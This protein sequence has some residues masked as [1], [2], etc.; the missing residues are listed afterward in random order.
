MSKLVIYVKSF[1]YKLIRKLIQRSCIHTIII[2]FTGID[3]NILYVLSGGIV[4][5]YDPTR[6]VGI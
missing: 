3:L 5:I 6:S 2:C 4:Y 1:I